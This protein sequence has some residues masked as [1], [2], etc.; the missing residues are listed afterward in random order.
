M[1]SKRDACGIVL[2]M[3]THFVYE[4]AQEEM[5]KATFLLKDGIYQCVDCN[6][7]TNSRI[8]FRE[9]VRHHILPYPYRC[10]CGTTVAS[11]PDLRRHS[12]SYH[13]KTPLQMYFEDAEQLLDDIFS[14]IGSERRTFWFPQRTRHDSSA[15]VENFSDLCDAGVC[16][17]VLNESNVTD[18]ERTD[19]AASR[20][21]GH[22]ANAEPSQK[23]NLCVVPSADDGSRPLRKGPSSSAS[24]LDFSTEYNYINAFSY[25]AAA[26]EV[27][28]SNFCILTVP[29]DR[30]D[31][32]QTDC[33]EAV[34][35]GNTKQPKNLPIK[36][37]WLPRSED[38][39]NVQSFDNTLLAPHNV[40]TNSNLLN[41]S[42]SLICTDNGLMQVGSDAELLTVFSRVSGRGVE[43]SPIRQDNRMESLLDVL[44][45]DEPVPVSGPGK[46][47]FCDEKFKCLTCLSWETVSEELFKE[48][49][50]Q[51][52]H[53][54]SRICN[55]IECL[56]KD[57][58][59]VLGMVMLVKSSLP[60][61][62]MSE[63]PPSSD[64]RKA[65][66]VSSSK[67][68][69][70]ESLCDVE[71]SS[72][73]GEN[74][75]A[76]KKNSSAKTENKNTDRNL[77]EKVTLSSAE[78]LLFSAP[79]LVSLRSKACRH[80]SFNG[81]VD[82][83]FAGKGKTSQKDG[84]AIEFGNCREE[85]ACV[86]NTELACK[87]SDA[88]GN[89]STPVSG[90]ETIS[91]RRRKQMLTVKPD[92]NRPVEYC[93]YSRDATP[94]STVCDQ[95][96]YTCN[97]SVQLSWHVESCHPKLAVKKKKEFC[98]PACGFSDNSKDTLIW[99]MAHHIG[100]HTLKVFACKYCS[101]QSTYMSRIM[102]HVFHSHPGKALDVQRESTNI[103]YMDGIFKCPFCFS[104]YPWG[105]LF[106][107]HIED[108]HK[109]KKLAGHLAHAYRKKRCPEVLE[110]P[111]YLV[112]KYM[113]H[114]T[115][116]DDQSLMDK[117]DSNGSA[118]PCCTES[119]D[120]P[121][122]LRSMKNTTDSHSKNY[123]EADDGPNDDHVSEPDAPQ[124]TELTGTSDSS[125]AG[126]SSAKSVVHERSGDVGR[127]SNRNVQKSDTETNSEKRSK[128][129]D[130]PKGNTSHWTLR[131]NMGKATQNDILYKSAKRRIKKYQSPKANK[132][133]FLIAPSCIPT[134]PRNI[135]N[136][137]ASNF[138]KSLPNEF[139]FS[140]A[141][142]CPKCYYTDRIRL[143]LIR[144]YNG[145]LTE[146][147]AGVET[148]ETSDMQAT[149]GDGVTFSLWNPKKSHK[150]VPESAKPV[151]K[152]RKLPVVVSEEKYKERSQRASQKGQ[153]E[154]YKRTVK[155]AKLSDEVSKCD[156]SNS[157]TPSH[158]MAD[159][160][161]SGPVISIDDSTSSPSLTGSSD[162][163]MTSKLTSLGS[164]PA[165]GQFLQNHARKT[166]STNKCESCSTTFSS[167]TEYEKH[168][169][170]VHSLTYYLCRC[171]G[172]MIRGL[173]NVQLHFKEKHPR[174]QVLVD[175]WDSANKECKKRI[176]PFSE[177]S[178]VEL[179][180]KKIKT[181]KTDGK[182]Q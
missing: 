156:A 56:S 69:A 133:S 121:K 145:H 170:D 168:A 124:N 64:E 78:Q 171:C 87:E 107:R 61:T 180:A 96:S 36:W 72:P 60:S 120:V 2:H 109:L 12:S 31:E 91:P 138:E 50:W 176:R 102:K 104:G 40:E 148:S 23:E 81:E 130:Q 113:I 179:P 152:K 164:S 139:I 149:K 13:P 105:S 143:N 63:C 26:R 48:H 92:A 9:H 14:E 115:S 24:V 19:N 86:T 65:S 123:I 141:I 182:K 41:S 146:A 58:P 47:V 172:L 75:S 151:M 159:T 167:E 128:N 46:F 21:S 101:R 114:A 84:K 85:V 5:A 67:R 57:C 177:A 95:C 90:E 4:T 80:L 88:T 94:L 160:T 140:Q 3:R 127:K 15:E 97:C 155:R 136:H 117:N 112:P 111:K 71:P 154:R 54:N 20:I 135:G 131:P 137:T 166:V 125:N 181:A 153:S 126:F 161:N 163:H 51:H 22:R 178:D 142:K 35:Q 74:F 28:S 42:R 157:R 147:S 53:G 8:S 162:I 82:G 99:H 68:S 134:L 33:S 32:S 25:S 93:R 110:F 7:R 76:Q 11:I 119:N 52:F 108:Q 83:D 34:V 62:D 18:I 103:A 49:V 106:F 118:T 10:H 29:D 98:C 77:F 174:S 59:L 17:S 6:R 132:R 16:G 175:E 122:I 38:I 173:S 45:L 89:I 30:L 1:Y 55:K 43:V 144:H 100:E 73:L 37:Q 39:S 169:R 158:G 44:S 165:F 79:S 66:N 129:L 116:K 70:V 27:D 150:E